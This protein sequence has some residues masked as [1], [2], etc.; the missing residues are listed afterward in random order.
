MDKN[1]YIFPRQYTITLISSKDKC[2]MNCPLT[3]STIVLKVLSLL[4]ACGRSTFAVSCL[5]CFPPPL[6]FF[7]S[8]L[9]GDWSAPIS[10]ERKVDGRGRPSR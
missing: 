10:G 3:M 9:S 7:Y 1:I 8:I 5:P 6:L 2:D 4:S